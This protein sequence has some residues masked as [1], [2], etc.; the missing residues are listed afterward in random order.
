M[1]KR[2]GIYIVVVGLLLAMIT[3]AADLSGVWRGQYTSADGRHHRITFTM[4]IEDGKV[5]G[6]VNGTVNKTALLDGK[7]SGD[8]VDFWAQWPYGKFHYQGKLTGE[9]ILFTV[10]AGDYKSEM[11]ANRVTE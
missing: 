4:K 7:A 9:A 2:I 5:T 11:T 3:T 8:E 1:A 6:T 10:Q